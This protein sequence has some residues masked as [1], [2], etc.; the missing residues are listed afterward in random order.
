[1]GIQLA[2]LLYKQTEYPFFLAS[3]LLSPTLLAFS[4]QV[5]T[6]PFLANIIAHERMKAFAYI[7]IVEVVA[8]LFVAYAIY[9]SPFH[10]NC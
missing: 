9:I 7:S 6:V 10:I 8:K 3:L 1:M 2:D 4:I 5:I